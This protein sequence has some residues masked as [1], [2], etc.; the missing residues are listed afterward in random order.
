MQKANSK[1]EEQRL[2]LKKNKAMKKLE[3][4]KSKM[5]KQLVLNTRMERLGRDK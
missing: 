1:R 5:K 4:A 3:L 2:W